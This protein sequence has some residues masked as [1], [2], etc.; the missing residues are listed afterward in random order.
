MQDPAAELYYTTTPYGYVFNNP[1]RFIDPT[2]AIVEDADNIVKEHKAL[3][4][5]NISLIGDF[6]TSG[7]I[8]QE[9][10]SKLI[11]FNKSMLGEIRELEN[12]EQVYTVSNISGKEGGVSYD[13][14]TEKI[15]IEI[16]TE[17]KNRSQLLAHELKHAYQFEKGKV[18][19]RTDGS[20]YGSLYDIT[21]ETES[22]NRERAFASGRDYFD[23]RVK[24]FNDKDTREFGKSLVPPAY[25]SL[26]SGPIDI[27]SSIGKALKKRT[28]EAGKLGKPVNEVYKGWRKHYLRGS[29]K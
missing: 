2:G 17:S 6:I 28:I 16:G 8:S 21:D 13:H 10:G 24:I 29:K 9:V 3:L 7:A 26:P 20:G 1:L 23:G 15:S 5:N 25:Q 11:G 27:N 19:F 18:S 22:Y 14:S 12:S 4:N